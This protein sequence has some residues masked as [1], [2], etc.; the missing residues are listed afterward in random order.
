MGRAAL[1]RAIEGK[2]RTVLDEYERELLAVRAVGAAA[3]RSVADVSG[4]PEV[5][6]GQYD[7]QAE[8]GSYGDDHLNLN[9]GSSDVHRRFSPS[10]HARTR[11]ARERDRR[12][13][14]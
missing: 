5:D 11:Y 10:P 7:H 13:A 1:D 14:L 12:G 6:E 8:D 4:M 2:L 3:Q 9:R